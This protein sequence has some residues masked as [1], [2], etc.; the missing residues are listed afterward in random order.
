MT[1][2]MHNVLEPPSLDDLLFI[3]LADRVVG[4]QTGLV[5]PVGPWLLVMHDVGDFVVVRSGPYC[6]I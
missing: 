4:D 3:D 2:V 6:S 1:H 5:G